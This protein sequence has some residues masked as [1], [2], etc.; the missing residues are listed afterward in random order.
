MS[1]GPSRRAAAGA[2]RRADSARLASAGLPACAALLAAVAALAPTPADAR[3]ESLARGLGPIRWRD[4]AK[5]LRVRLSRARLDGDVLVVPRL[6]RV[7]P[8]VSLGATVRFTAA[9]PGAAARVAEIGL[10]VEHGATVDPARALVLAWDHLDR[11]LGL[12]RLP[13]STTRGLALDGAWAD[14][15][16]EGPRALVLLRA[17]GPSDRARCAQVLTDLL[18]VAEADASLAPATRRRLVLSPPDARAALVGSC[19][20]RVD[21]AEARCV[22]QAIRWA[23]ARACV[24]TL[25]PDLP[26]D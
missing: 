21:D 13:A 18:R 5:A 14:V 19:L 17:A 24:P 1:I 20:G 11:R 25:A 7:G 12:G 8:S 3:P 15:V 23:D 10:H 16:R 6:T 2:P 4:D 9:R 26:R 22:A